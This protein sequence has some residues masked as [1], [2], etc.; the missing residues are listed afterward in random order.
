[1][2]FLFLGQG[3]S[4]F[5]CFW[6]RAIADLLVFLFPDSM[7]KLRL[8]I[9]FK[10]RHRSR[11]GLCRVLVILGDWETELWNYNGGCGVVVVWQRDVGLVARGRQ[12]FWAARAWCLL[13]RCYESSTNAILRYIQESLFIHA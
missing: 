8:W 7:V 2:I 12:R 1:M 11:C 13:L 6:W 3:A 10:G 4:R 5:F 9:Q